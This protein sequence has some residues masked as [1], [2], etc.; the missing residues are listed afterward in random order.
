LP[1]L[2]RFIRRQL[3]VF[4]SGRKGTTIFYSVKLF[5]AFLK[6]NFCWYIFFSKNIPLQLLLGIFSVIFIQMAD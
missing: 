2:A 4:K 5:L 3:V 1:Y 6:K